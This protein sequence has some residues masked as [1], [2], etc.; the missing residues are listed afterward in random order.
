[1]GAFIGLEAAPLEAVDD[2]FFRPWNKTGLV[3]IFDPKDEFTAVLAG[4]QIVVEYGPYA[5]EVK[6]TG[7]AGGKSQP[8]F[9]AHKDEGTN[10]I[11]N[12]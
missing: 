1:V 9:F 8:Y 10:P 11:L 7:G 6:A 3:G 4:E 12:P 2:I 5:T